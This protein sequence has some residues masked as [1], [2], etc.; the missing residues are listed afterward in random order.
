[1]ADPKQS[2]AGES[3][4]MTQAEGD[5]VIAKS[6]GGDGATVKD[7]TNIETKCARCN[8]QKSDN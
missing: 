8:N 4:D 5:H 3:K 2:K 6:K 7:M 1:M